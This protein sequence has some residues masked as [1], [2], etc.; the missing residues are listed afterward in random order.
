MAARSEAR[1]HEQLLLTEKCWHERKVM[2]TWRE[3]GETRFLYQLSQAEQ[4]ENDE[5]ASFI[6]QQRKQQG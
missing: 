1:L 2:D 6:Y 4:R 3:K 5:M